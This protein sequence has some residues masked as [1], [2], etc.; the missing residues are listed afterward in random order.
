MD[1]DKEFIKLAISPPNKN[2]RRLIMHGD[3]IDSEL[4]DI[5]CNVSSPN[6]VKG[7]ADSRTDTSLSKTPYNIELKCP[8]C[9]DTFVRE[10][11]REIIL[12]ILKTTR[13]SR[14]DSHF[15]WCNADINLLW[16]DKCKTEKEE[17]DRLEK[18]R[19]EKENETFRDYYIE[20]YINPNRSF[21]SEIRPWERIS[22][23]M[24]KFKCDEFVKKAVAS[25]T[26]YEFLN[27]P[28]WEGVRQYKLKK[29]EYKCELCGKSG[30][31]NV[32]HKTYDRHGME[33]VRSV[34]DKDLIVLC[35]DCHRKFH[36]KLINNR[37]EN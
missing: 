37:K 13:N 32:H 7:F 17:R 23:I 29:A 8:N 18:I 27:T 26:Y 12:K 4:V 21:K 30:I 2:D 16:C 19:I 22:S 31:L 34:A 5:L 25:L 35:K 14:R 28:Y 11:N 20:Q 24:D 36:E 3:F 10:G 15:Y 9:G 1:M 6:M 33:H